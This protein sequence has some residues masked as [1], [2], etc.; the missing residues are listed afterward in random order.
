M[1]ELDV[2]LEGDNAWPDLIDKQDSIIHV[3]NITA[4]ARLP[5]GMASG[6][7]SVSVRIDLPDGQTVIA[8]T[9]MDLFQAAAQAFKA[10]EEM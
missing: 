8:E 10:R 5:K 4:V 1:L 7:S 3:Q 9:S 2:I 6:K